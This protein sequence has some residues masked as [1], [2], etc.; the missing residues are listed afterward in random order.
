M[1]AAVTEVEYRDIPGFPGYRVGDDG[2][3]WSRWK[4]VCLGGRGGSRFV[5]GDTWSRL[6]SPIASQRSPYPRITLYRDGAKFSRSVHQVVMLSFIGP[7]P[8][9]YEVAH[10]NGVPADCR[11]VN[12]SYKTFSANQMDRRRHGTASIGES[13][14]GAKLNNESVRA[15]LAARAAG[16]ISYERLGRQ[17]GV[18]KKTAM[19]VVSRQVW[20]HVDG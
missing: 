6:S 15:I 2:S 14:P 4:R 18:S 8:D 16:G 19:L 20:G 11:L 5:L 9:G 13:H 10:E 1:D 3:V 12:L 7:C 17:F